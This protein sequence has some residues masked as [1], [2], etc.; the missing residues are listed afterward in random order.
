M[1]LDKYHCMNKN[2]GWDSV[3]VTCKQ[4][5]IQ[6]LSYTSNDRKGRESKNEKSW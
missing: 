6:L 1:K 2:W 5:F 4:R 3:N